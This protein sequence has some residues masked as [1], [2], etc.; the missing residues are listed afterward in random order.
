LSRAVQGPG[1][2]TRAI[3]GVATDLIRVSDRS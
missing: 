3:E 2:P 1:V